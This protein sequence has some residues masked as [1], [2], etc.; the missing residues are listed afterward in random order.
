[1]VEAQDIL[2]N[3]GNETS[4]LFY[5]AVKLG[6]LGIVYARVLEGEQGELN[7]TRTRSSSGF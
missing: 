5:K 4:V 3:D 1:M 2:S 7:R 6:F